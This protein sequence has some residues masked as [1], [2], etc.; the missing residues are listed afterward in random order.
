VKDSTVIQKYHDT[1]Y[2]V[3]ANASHECDIHKRLCIF[4]FTCTNIYYFWD[5]I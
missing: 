5:Y 4:L 1:D 2:S 3:R